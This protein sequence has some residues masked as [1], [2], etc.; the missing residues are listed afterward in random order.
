M[1]AKTEDYLTLAEVAGETGISRT[2]L[3]THIQKGRLRANKLGFFT[4]VHK[5]AVAEFKTHLR[6]LTFGERV[7]TI[8]QQ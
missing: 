1:K 5:D 2:T 3:Y 6:K 7:I 4:V 8:Y